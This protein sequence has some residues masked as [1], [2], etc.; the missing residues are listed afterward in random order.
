MLYLDEHVL[1]S[2]KDLVLKTHPGPMPGGEEEEGGK[3]DG[4]AS[5]DGLLDDEL[6]QPDA[7]G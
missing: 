3:D 2:L 5:P 1:P 6:L 4:R 7:A